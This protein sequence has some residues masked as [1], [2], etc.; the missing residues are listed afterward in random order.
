M[1]DN[2]Y[3]EVLGVG[4]EAS[5][6]QIKEA[7]RKLAL[8]YHPDRNRDNPEAMEKMQAVNE[9]YAV[10]SHPEKRRD[11]DAMRDRFGASAYNRFRQSYTQDDIFKESDI[12]QIF[13]EMTRSFGLR[14]FDEVFRDLAEGSAYR[15]FRYQ[16]PGFRAQGFFFQAGPGRG[17]IRV[18]VPGKAGP[19]GKLGRRMFEKIGGVEFAEDGQDLHDTIRIDTET[20]R[21]GG[22]YAY[23]L[24]E[25]DKK[26]VIR[27]P[28]GIRSG[29]QIR[30]A[31]QGKEGKGGGKPGDL[32]LE[33][34]IKQPLLSGIRQ[35]ARRWLSK[36]R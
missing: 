33:V 22:P 15:T 30:L 35:K 5:S 10:L 1:Q 7:Y 27:V 8:R 23:Y 32:Y 28:A 17:R 18:K 3:Y 24:R 6:R 16:R 26:L 20:A 25:K 21:R 14:G 2:D 34:K 13:E 36:K 12:F 19:L 9:A 11:Y 4:K 29:Q 31:G